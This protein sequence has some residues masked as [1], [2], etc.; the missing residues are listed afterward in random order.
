[1]SISSFEDQ[2]PDVTFTTVSRR[3]PLASCDVCP[4]LVQDTVCL[5]V[6]LLVST[7]AVCLRRVEPDQRTNLVRYEDK[8]DDQTKSTASFLTFIARCSNVTL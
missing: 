7:E 1:M 4:P 5:G 8:Q 2:L 3:P 6:G